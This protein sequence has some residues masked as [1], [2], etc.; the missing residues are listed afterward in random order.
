MSSYLPRKILVPVDLS[1]TSPQVLQTA[2]NLVG[3]KGTEIHVLHV[4]DKSHYRGDHVASKLSMS[5][6]REDAY[7]ASESH[8]EILVKGVSTDRA[9]KTCL[10]WGDP[11]MDIVRM[12]KTGDFDLIVMATHERRGINRFFSGSV[13]EDVMQRAPCSV[14]I[15]RKKASRAPSSRREKKVAV[16]A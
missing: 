7:I 2:V 6:M 13:A 15:L 3:W 11:A 1:E 10:L 8:L 4:A 16:P 9:I 14:L 5:K 12:A